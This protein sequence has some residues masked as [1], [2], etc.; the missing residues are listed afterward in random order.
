MHLTNPEHSAVVGRRRMI[1]EPM[2]C[3]IF[4]SATCTA[5]GVVDLRGSFAVLPWGRIGGLQFRRRR[6]YHD[7]VAHDQR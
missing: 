7:A 1:A 5:A 4:P 2:D 3:A 6:C